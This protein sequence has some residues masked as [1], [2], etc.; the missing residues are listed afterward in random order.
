MQYINDV[1]YL[2]AKYFLIKPYNTMFILKN[3]YWISLLVG[4]FIWF[5]I[6]NYKSENLF[7]IAIKRLS[8]AS[9]F[10][11]YGF[12]LLELF[13]PLPDSFT[14]YAH[15]LQQQYRNDFIDHVGVS[16]LICWGIG[17]GIGLVGYI[18]AKRLF[19]IK[20][21][22]LVGLFT[23]TNFNTTMSTEQ[24]AREMNKSNP[25]SYNPVRYFKVNKGLVFMNWDAETNKP[26]YEEYKNFSKKHAQFLGRSQS[27]KNLGIQPLA[28]QMMQFGELVIMLDVKNGG[29]DIMAPLLYSAAKEMNQPYNY[30]EFG[31]SAT[32]QFNILQ[33]KNVDIIQEIILQICN[34]QETS[35]MATDY[36][37]KQAKLIA[38]NIAKFVA[39]SADEIS[40]RN[41]MTSYYDKF[42]NPAAKDSEKSKI[43]TS[44]Q[45]LADWDCIN[46]K[47]GKSIDQI[48]SDG[49]VWYIQTINKDAYVIIQ[50]IISTLLKLQ[51][52]QRK[53]C[54]IAD[55]FFKYIN[56]DL[57][58]VFTESGGKGIH[59]LVA[60][61]TAALLKAPQLNITSQDMIG[62]LFANCS[63]SYVYGSNDP[64]ILEQ[65]EKM[66]GKIKV[67]VATEQT[68][69]GYTLVDKGTGEKSYR[70]QDVPKITKDMLNLLRDRECF[71]LFAGR[72][73]NR[74]HTGII[75][76][77]DGE[78][79]KDNIEFID[80]KIQSRNIHTIEQC[81]S[82]NNNIQIKNNINENPF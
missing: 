38:L 29:D 43:E 11:Y 13:S 1:F 56:K 48:I 2:L 71:L 80:L 66:G 30:M 20:L 24:L 68:K 34:I 23:K 81:D 53:V 14:E 54:L 63:Y 50:A 57:I 72:P 5:G 65:L 37:Q 73:T 79:S 47:N 51:K 61:Q 15:K 70:E 19:G 4:F 8:L 44:L 49:G 6:H 69:R 3:I 27:G 10:L 31:V 41:I 62:T 78:F 64:F 26:V 75:D 82:M 39:N 40:I 7:A 16:V 46:A 59:C 18:M 21:Q 55:E 67:Q 25:K 17:C 28:I 58:E 42:F 35:D 32:Y 36:Y 76:I 12:T 45:I 22:E 74:T 9:S 77:I 33:T 52:R 60:Y